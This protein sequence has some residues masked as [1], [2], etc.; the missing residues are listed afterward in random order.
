MMLTIT[1]C[2]FAHADR[3]TRETAS[4]D[5]SLRAKSTLFSEDQ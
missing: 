4:G 5:G 1:A 3:K 2:G